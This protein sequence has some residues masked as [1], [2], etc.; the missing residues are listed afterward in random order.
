DPA[1]LQLG[2]RWACHL[3]LPD[4]EA[5]RTC[6]KKEIHGRHFSASAPETISINSLVM[7]AWRA[8]LYCSVYLAMSSPEFLVA[9]SM[10]TIR[11]ACSEATDS[12]RARQT[13]ISRCRGKSSSSTCWALGSKR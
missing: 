1:V 11:A 9:F 6:L 5:G 2:V 12:S 10:A 8:R 7:Y 4:V 3:R 13:C